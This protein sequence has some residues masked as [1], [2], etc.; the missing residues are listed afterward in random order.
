[1][2]PRGQAEPSAERRWIDGHIQGSSD[3]SR[4]EF[5]KLWP[6]IHAL[7]HG[8][9]WE[10]RRDCLRQQSQLDPG[11]KQGYYKAWSHPRPGVGWGGDGLSLKCAS[12]LTGHDAFKIKLRRSRS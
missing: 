4:S 7:C 5:S 1:M 9:D 12:S 2:R 11:W 6:K 8:M 3:L 10:W